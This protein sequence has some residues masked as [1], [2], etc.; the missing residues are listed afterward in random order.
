[1]NSQFVYRPFNPGEEAEVSNLV[2]KSFNEFVGTDFPEEGIEEFFNY[3]NPRALLKRL[4][5]NHFVLV[6]EAEGSIAGM[7]EIREMRHISMLFVDK[8]HHRKGIGKELVRLALDK[9]KSDSRPPKKVTVHSS[10]FA[11][12]F[13]KSLGFVPTENE[14]II[15][16]VVH[17]PMALDLSQCNIFRYENPAGQE[18]LGR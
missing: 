3:A 14:K 12:P 16:G 17:I 15:H 7:I 10:R 8:A 6:A 5:G 11:A 1:M 18:I 9:I 13:Y 4:N 2:A